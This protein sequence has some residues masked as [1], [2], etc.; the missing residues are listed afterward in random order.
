MLE[1]FEEIKIEILVMIVAA[2][3][4]T[5]LRGAIPLGIS[6][7]LSPVHSTAIS[8]VGNIAIVPILLKV[9]EPV[10]NYFEKTLLFSK[11]IGWIKRRTLKKT[12][13]TIKKYSLLG[14]FVLVAVPIPT[15]GVWTGCI[16]ASLLKLNYRDALLVIS[17]GV[18][19]SG[20][21]VHAISYQIFSL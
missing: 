19:T 12:K 6:L 15:T 5:E 14:L 17:S 7:G 16:A 18:L 9:L 21:I 11:T 1:L 10:M 8:I 3:P 2:M 4:I 20:I 13:S